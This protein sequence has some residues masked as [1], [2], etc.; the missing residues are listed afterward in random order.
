MNLI[1]SLY[2]VAIGLL[3]A[4]FVGFG[5]DA[6]YPSPKEPEPPTTTQYKSFEEM[7]KE[8]KTV[9]K[10]YD[11]K[12]KEFQSN[13]NKYNQN[14]SIIIIA[15]AVLILAASILGLS[16]IE[17]IGEGA[18]L[19]AVFTLFYGIA[20]AIATQE[21]KFRFIAITIALVIIVGLTYW[22]FLKNKLPTTIAKNSSI[23]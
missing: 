10:E 1:R 2:I 14:L 17:L 16:R 4:A 22:K 3:V 23:K 9:Q 6:F 13:L 7:T 5:V 15:L 20:R 21:A 8:D 19:G 12:Y 11:K 18:T